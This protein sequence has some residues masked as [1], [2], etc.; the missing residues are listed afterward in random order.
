M[1]TLQPLAE[2]VSSTGHMG[3]F[4]RSGTPSRGCMHMFNAGL[5]HLA[6]RP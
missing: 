5:W 6:Q 2:P 3:L 1:V 4:S